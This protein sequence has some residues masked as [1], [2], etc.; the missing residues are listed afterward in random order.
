MM[1]KVTFTSGF[2]REIRHLFSV[3]DADPS[4]AQINPTN[5]D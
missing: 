1:A 3:P 5:D 4:H 2:A